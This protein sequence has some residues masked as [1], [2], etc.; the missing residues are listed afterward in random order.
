M[1]AQIQQL[2][3]TDDDLKKQVAT[4]KTDAAPPP[5]AATTPDSGAMAGMVSAQMAQ[6][7]DQKFRLL[8]SR[9]HLTPEQQA[10]VKA[11]MD[12]ESKRNAAMAAKMMA[13]GKID[14]RVN[15]KDMKTVEQTLDQ[16]LTPDQKTAYE[17]MKTDQ[18]NSA[19]ETM[20]TI[21]MNQISPLLQLSD[22]QKDQVGTALY[23]AQL[24]SQDPAWIKNNVTTNAANPLAILD[25]KPRRKKMRFQKSSRRT[26]WPLTISRRK[27]SSICKRR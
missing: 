22:A 12:E 2:Q 3:S 5:V 9:L 25:A 14:P 4:L 17:Q 24:D 6:A 20:A 11:A 8:N 10:A 13:G 21:E 19:A 18:K 26:S 23:Q 27:V 16:I 1:S 7:S 15:L